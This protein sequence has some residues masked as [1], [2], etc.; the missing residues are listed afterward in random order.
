MALFDLLYSFGVRMK[1]GTEF[2]AYGREILLGWV[3]QYAGSPDRSFSVLDVGCG[4]GADLL[5]I[6][7]A[8][9]H[10]ADLFGIETY[11]PNQQIC[12]A[13]GIKIFGVNIEEQPLPLPDHGLDI[14]IANQILEHCKELFFVFSEFSRVLKPG[15]LL[16]VG[17]P[18]LAAY[19]DRIALLL[20][21]Q[22]TCIKVLGPHIRG[23]TASGL[24]QFADCEGYFR[25]TD[26]RGCGFYP[27]PV[28]LSRLL[29]RLF[30]TFSTS[31][32]LCFERTDKPGTFDSVL[33]SRH[34]ETPFK[35]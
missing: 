12:D 27:F 5:N 20:G 1:E 35:S 17:V 24:R 14:I 33:K 8:G 19:H 28:F 29:S 15:G 30:P 34:F 25:M 4:K 31:I 23:F 11:P 10:Q 3:R 9:F 6:K 16:L 26:R 21:R 18:N 2:L 22:P 32:H 7:T 13:A